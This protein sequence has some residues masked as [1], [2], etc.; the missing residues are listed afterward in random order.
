MIKDL[1]ERVMNIFL[2]EKIFQINFKDWI[3]KEQNPGNTV[4]F[5]LH[6]SGKS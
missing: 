1:R 6:S 4:R 5:L 2:F 3:K